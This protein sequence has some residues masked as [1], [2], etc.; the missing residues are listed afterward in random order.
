MTRS[1][2]RE[3]PAGFLA[4]FPGG[5]IIDE[6]Q[7]LPSLLSYIQVEVDEKG[8]NG[9]YILTGSQQL[10]MSANISQSLAGRT[11]IL[12]LLPFSC[13]EVKN[14]GDFG[15]DDLL[16]RGFYPRIYN[17][18]LDSMQ[19]Y[20]DYFETYIERDVRQ[21]AELKNLSLFEKFVRLCAGRVGQLLNLNSMANDVGVSQTTVR[22]WLSLLETSFVVF[23]LQPFHANIRK[24]LVKTPKLY[25]YDVG[26]AA[27]LCGI[28]TTAHI[29]NHPLRGHL[30][31]NMVIAEILKFRFNNGKRNNLSFFRDNTGNEVDVLY[32]I[33]D[34]VAPIEIKVG[35]TVSSDYFKNLITFRKLGLHTLHKGFVAY[36]GDIEQNRQDGHVLNF[37][38]IINELAKM[39]KEHA[40]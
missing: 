18:N 39:E 31:E 2:A 36:A 4:Q 8:E 14:F 25:F 7:R 22:E 35:Q 17:E 10:N 5:A 11:A 19:F 1:F 15:L 21:L 32:H 30:F 9:R 20:G 28:E 26:L 29:R 37:K 6:I 38:N 34:K 40:G 3:D 12:R 16:V 23:L 33:A 24:R 27:W 13:V